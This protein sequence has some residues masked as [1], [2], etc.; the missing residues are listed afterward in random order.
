M[1]NTNRYGWQTFAVPHSEGILGVVGD[2]TM[3]KN[4]SATI[5]TMNALNPMQVILQNQMLDAYMK[6]SGDFGLGANMNQVNATLMQDAARR[7]IDVNS[8]AFQNL[9]SSAYAS[10]AAKDAEQRKAWGLN[11]MTSGPQYYN[12]MQQQFGKQQGAGFGDF[13]G[14]FLG[15]MGGVAGA[16]G[17]N[18]ILPGSGVLKK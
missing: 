11:L 10:A 6:G 17:M 13:V 7:G 4:K 14:S 1:P 3:N 9:L 5:N 18:A 15:G 16:Y 2:T 8:A 12:A